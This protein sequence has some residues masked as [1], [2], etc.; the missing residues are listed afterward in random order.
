MLPLEKSGIVSLHSFVPTNVSQ[1]RRQLGP[2]LCNDPSGGAADLT[3]SR[4]GSSP[5]SSRCSASRSRGDIP[6]SLRASPRYG[7]E[8]SGNDASALFASDRAPDAERK[9]ITPSRVR[10]SSKTFHAVEP[11]VNSQMKV[12]PAIST[13]IAGVRLALNARRYC[14]CVELSSALSSG[15]HAAAVVKAVLCKNRRRS[16]TSPLLLAQTRRLQPNLDALPVKFHLTPGL[17]DFY[18]EIST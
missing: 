11:I 9:V 14:V 1:G 2:V 18:F 3:R 12:C 16:M 15:T 13:L 6:M 5:P 17:I 7:G 4:S 10:K 8:S